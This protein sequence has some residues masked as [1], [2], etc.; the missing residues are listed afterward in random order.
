[1]S[2]TEYLPDTPE[3]IIIESMFEGYAEYYSA[4]LSQKV[5]DLTS[6]RDVQKAHAEN[7]EKQLE[8]QRKQY[9]ELRMEQKKSYE[10]Q[11]NELKD[12]YDKQLVQVKENAEKQPSV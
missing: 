8:G 5:T 6:E 11:I 7:A 1:M 10:I 12:S 9:E 3:R 4:E 2:A